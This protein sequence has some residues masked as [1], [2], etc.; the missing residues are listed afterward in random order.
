MDDHLCCVEDHLRRIHSQCVRSRVC[1]L[2]TSCVPAGVI[3]ADIGTD[4][5]FLPVEL[6]SSGQIPRA[7]ACDIGVGPLE[8]ARATIEEA[9]LQAQ[10]ALILPVKKHG[11]FQY[12]QRSDVYKRQALVLPSRDGFKRTGTLFT[13][14]DGESS[15]FKAGAAPRSR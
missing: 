6:V 9:G 14:L 13:L 2:Y 8:H 3:V 11:Q 5:A 10:I 7:Y 12:P 4:H 1:L 15:A